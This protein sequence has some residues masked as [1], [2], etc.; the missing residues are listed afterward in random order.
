MS[1]AWSSSSIS[2]VDAHDEADEEQEEV[3]ANEALVESRWFVGGEVNMVEVDDEVLGW[4]S[5]NCGRTGT[6]RERPERGDDDDD[7]D[8]E[9]DEEE[10]A[11]VLVV[12]EAVEAV[13]VGGDI[14]RDG[15]G[16]GE[17]D[18]DGELRCGGGVVDAELDRT[19]LEVELATLA[20]LLLLMIVANL[21]ADDRREACILRVSREGHVI[22]GT[23]ESER[24]AALAREGEGERCVG[25][26]DSS[27]LA[28]TNA[29]RDSWILAGHSTNQD[30]LRI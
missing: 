6:E 25:E 28:P 14:P 29:Q 18:G 20:P 3:E 16:D 21:S 26:K 24:A 15:V 8:V 23:P 11:V 22:S 9:E 10:L 19:M 7:D 5:A 13:D 12:E 4:E 27:K 2:S 1:L 30:A 17:D